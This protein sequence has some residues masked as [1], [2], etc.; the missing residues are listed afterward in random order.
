MRKKITLILSVMFAI[1]GFSAP[2]MAST[3]HKIPAS[4]WRVWTEDG[5]NMCI[6][7]GS[8]GPVSGTKVLQKSNHANCTRLSDLFIGN[9]VNGHPMYYWEFVNG[10]DIMAANESCTGVV[11]KDSIT[12][13]GVVW[14]LYISNGNNYFVPRFCNVNVNGMPSYVNRMNSSDVA[15]EQ[16]RIGQTGYQNLHLE[17]V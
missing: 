11:V 8:L 5:N 7:S 14:T 15:G 12:D 10:G 2:A 1:V 17:D 4:N 16:W 3:S 6:G 9:D 13:D